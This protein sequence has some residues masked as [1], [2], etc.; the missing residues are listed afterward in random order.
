MAGEVR[1][2]S[3]IS[4]Q[5]RTRRV[6]SHGNK[7]NNKLRPRYWAHCGLFR[8][9]EQIKLTEPGPAFCTAPSSILVGL[10]HSTPWTSTTTHRIHLTQYLHRPTRCNPQ[11]PSLGPRL[12][13]NKSSHPS[14]SRRPQVRASLSSGVAA[15]C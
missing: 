2:S 6:R 13:Q 8:L 4:G 12:S 1:S 3:E 10:C 15:P 9:L 14:S 11:T 7:S 5:Y